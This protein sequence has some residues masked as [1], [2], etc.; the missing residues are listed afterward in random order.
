[1]TKLIFKNIVPLNGTW[2][3]FDLLFH[4][5]M[6]NLWSENEKLFWSIGHWDNTGCDQGNC[7]W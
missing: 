4:H 7:H 1:M 3:M 5:L 2:P 6:G